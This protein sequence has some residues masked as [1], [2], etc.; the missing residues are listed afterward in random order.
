MQPRD[1]KQ[2]TAALD[3]EQIFLK[4]QWLGEQVLANEICELSK[5]S[6]RLGRGGI[7]AD[8]Q[9]VTECRVILPYRRLDMTITR[10]N[11]GG[12]DRST[13]CPGG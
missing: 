3:D 5:L 10:A 9:C 2:L 6:K 1:V 11:E 4:G 7:V 8:F 12:S 13:G